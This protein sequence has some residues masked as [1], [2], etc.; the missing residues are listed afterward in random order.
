MPRR[1]PKIVFKKLGTTPPS[2]TKASKTEFGLWE[3]IVSFAPSNGIIHIDPRQPE[4]EILD[5]MVHE[6]LHDAMPFLEEEAVEAYAT[7]IAKALWKQG[8][9]RTKE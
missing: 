9:R 6:L 8:Y 7:H 3:G 5:T 1:E 2:H 4:A